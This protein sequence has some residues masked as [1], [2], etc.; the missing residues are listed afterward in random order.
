MEFVHGGHWGALAQPAF[1]R[2]KPADAQ[3]AC[4]MAK[5][6]SAREN[7]ATEQTSYPA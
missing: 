6:T 2:F 5:S 1:L 4:T 3:D 7:P